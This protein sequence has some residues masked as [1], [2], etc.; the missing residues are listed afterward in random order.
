MWAC[1]KNL[2]I[3]CEQF[4][5]TELGLPKIGCGLDKL[6]WKKVFDMI[7]NVFKNK[8]IKIF[9]CFY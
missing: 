7:I 3:I 9:I 8:S 4:N 5:I 6:D 2:V 1:L